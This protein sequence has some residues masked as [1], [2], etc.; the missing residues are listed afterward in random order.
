MNALSALTG[1]ASHSLYNW[2]NE[3]AEINGTDLTILTKVLNELSSKS[4]SEI[5]ILVANAKLH[6]EIQSFQ[7]NEGEASYGN[8]KTI[9][10]PFVKPPLTPRNDD[11]NHQKNDNIDLS[12]QPIHTIGNQ[13]IINRKYFEK[14]LPTET[15]LNGFVPYFNTF[16]ELLERYNSPEKLITE[17]YKNDYSMLL[18]HPNDFFRVPHTV[19]HFIITVTSDNMEKLIFKGSRVSVQF[20]PLEDVLFGYPH[21]VLFDDSRSNIFYIHP[22]KKE[23]YWTLRSENKEDYP[24]N[25]KK[26]TKI[27][28]IWQ[29]KTT[30]NT[31]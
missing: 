10:P 11:G 16:G 25:D 5:K 22:G 18:A 21:L 6:K 12:L 30:A 17:H 29:V 26:I 14:F 2:R 7:V 15:D 31:F 24:D 20:V 27:A 1:I 13:Q 8:N 19:A 23:G 28:G 3:K 9:A 4:K